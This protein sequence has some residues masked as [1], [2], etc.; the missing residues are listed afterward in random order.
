MKNLKSFNIKSCPEFDSSPPR[1]RKIKLQEGDCFKHDD[2]IYTVVKT[3]FDGGGGRKE[4]YFPDGHHVWAAD[5][6]GEKIDFWQTGCFTR[7]IE[8]IEI[9]TKE[10]KK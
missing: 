9:V 5:E 2:K 3:T 7:M 4:D 6:N 10:E 1:L 8:K